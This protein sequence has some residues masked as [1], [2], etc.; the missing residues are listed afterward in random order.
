[1]GR[2]NKDGSRALRARVGGARVRRLVLVG[3]LALSSVPVLPLGAL[4]ATTISIDASLADWTGVRADPDNSSHDTQITDPDPDYPGQPDRDT[5][6]VNATWD[7]EY[8]YIAMRRTSGGTK[9]IVWAAYIDRGGDGLLQGSDV[10]CI[11]KTNQNQGRYADASAPDPTARILRYNQA[12]VGQGGPYLH[13]AGDPMGHDG[14]TPDGWA[15]IQSGQIVPS[16]PM[17][18]W[19]TADGIEFEGRVAWSDLGLAP[20]SL[21]AIHFA[22]ANGESLGQKWVPS[23]TRKWIG[24]PPEYLEENRG[25]VEDNVDDIWWLRQ[26]GVSVTPDNQGG[27]DAGDTVVYTHTVRNSSNT[28]DTLELAAASDQGWPIQITDTSGNPL[29]SVALAAGGTRTI[30]VRVTIPNGTADGTRDVTTVSATSRT[31]A[32]VTSSATDTTTSG[33][34]TV[35]PDQAGS[36]A[37]G[38]TIAYTFTVGNNMPG[39]A[40]TYDLTTLGSMGWPTQITTLGGTPITS[41]TLASGTSTETVV[42][43]TVPA[44]ATAGLQDSTRLTAQLQGLPSVRSFATATTRVLD[45]LGIAPDNTG[46]AGAN[47]PI[48]YRHTIT[49]SWPTTRTVTLSATSSRGWPVAYFAADGVTQITTLGVG[50]NGAAADIFAR[51]TV[52]AGTAP[53]TT[54]ITTVRATVGGTTVTATDTTTVRRL[55][56]Y[57]DTSYTSPSDEFELTDEVFARATGLAAGDTVFFV[58]Y[59]QNGTPVRTSTDRTV[60][61]QGMQFDSYDTQLADPI[62]T[63]WRVELWRRQGKNNVSLLET[64]IFKVKDKARITALAASDAPGVGSDVAVTS[65]VENLIDKPITGSTMT[66]VVWWDEN[67]DGSLDAGDT[68]IDSSG[69]P[70]SWDGTSPISTHV[71]SGIDVGGNGT[72]TE[73]VAWTV[74]NRLFPHQGD[75]NVTATW[76]RSTGQL[77]DVKTTQFFSIPALGWPVFAGVVALA[78]LLFSRR[79]RVPGGEGP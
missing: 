49:N 19:L 1:M 39:V 46:Y 37:P 43:V 7:N 48:L 73:P 64:T 75:Y 77:I 50:P 2:R 59:D 38:Q 3:L 20:G 67:G 78:A 33:R 36:M 14:E 26:R 12:I 53:N 76:R 18:G 17:D 31:D 8:L 68:W 66:Y 79:L 32:T 62:G 71:T 57:P 55:M 56:T 58:W 28:S 70:R 25:Q 22:N 72:W 42:R 40:R 23:D 34:V 65:S 51:I 13:P 74:N 10:V 35:T 54:D 30:R 45:G 29:S 24:N 5:Y 52:P 41:V 21:I 63:T 27:G 11:W 69:A 9:A 16:R 6:L 61:T 44:T 60:D 47:S 15:D 4:T